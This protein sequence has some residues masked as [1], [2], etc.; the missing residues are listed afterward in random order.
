GV[1][2]NYLNEQELDKLNRIVSL[3]LD[4]AELQAKNR[5]AMYMKDW[6]AKL[7]DFLRLSENEILTHVGKISH[8]LAM[9]HAEAEFERYKQQQLTEKS[10]IEKDFEES[11]KHL[12]KL[13]KSPK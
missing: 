7:D 12:E 2:K 8:K 9:Q 11:L 1:A 5:R 4:F 6:I 13:E 10:A 3:Y